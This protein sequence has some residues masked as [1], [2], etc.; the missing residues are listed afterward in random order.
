MFRGQR[1]CRFGVNFG[2]FLDMEVPPNQEPAS[3]G[4]SEQGGLGVQDGAVP[5]CRVRTTILGLNLRRAWPYS[6]ER[7]LRVMC[8]C[9]HTENSQVLNGTCMMLPCPVCR[10]PLCPVHVALYRRKGVAF[11]ARS[12]I[13]V[14]LMQS[15]W[16]PN[17]L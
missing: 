17:G 10:P 5:Q 1:E 2:V 3:R 11:V 12:S 6:M 4:F 8:L 16:P 7:A 9:S 13:I 14:S 15:S